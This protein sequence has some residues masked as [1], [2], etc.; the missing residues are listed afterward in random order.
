MASGYKLS[1]LHSRRVLIE[2]DRGDKW[3]TM[4]G[5]AEYDRRELRIAIRDPAGD[6]TLLLDEANWNGVIADA[7]DGI[8]YLIRLHPPAQ[9]WI[10]TCAGAINPLPCVTAPWPWP[11]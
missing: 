3:V 7:P 6:F 1:E 4:E 9:A 10:N 5:I 2:W 11:G 8:G